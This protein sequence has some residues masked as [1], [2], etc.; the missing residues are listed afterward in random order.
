M[1]IQSLRQRRLAADAI[2]YLLRLGL[3]PVPIRPCGRC[4]ISMPADHTCQP[5]PPAHLPDEGVRP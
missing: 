3:Y 5:V 2:A 4:G 1:S